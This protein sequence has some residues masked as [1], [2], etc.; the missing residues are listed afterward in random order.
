MLDK[1]K[2]INRYNIAA[3]SILF[4]YFFVFAHFGFSFDDGGYLYGAGWRLIIGEH[5]YSDYIYARPPMSPIISWFLQWILNDSH[6]Y[7]KIRYFFYAE[8]FIYS[9]LS[10]YLINKFFNLSKE[11]PIFLTGTLVFVINVHFNNYLWHTT[12]G[13]FFSVISFYFITKRKMFWGSVFLLFA[14]LS[15]QS[16]YPLLFMYPLFIYI[17]FKREDDDIGEKVENEDFIFFILNAFLVFTIF[18]MFILLFFNKEFFDYLSLHQEHTQLKPFL[19]AGF[20]VYLINSAFFW[21]LATI[22]FFFSEENRR[23][24]FN[25]KNKFSRAFLTKKTLDF[26]YVFNFS[27]LFFSLF[28]LFFLDS[29]SIKLYHMIISF[30]L[31][32]FLLEELYLFY[33][34]RE[35]RRFIFT[36]VFISIAWCS[37]LSWGYTTPAFYA[38]TILFLY[39]LHH[40]EI[41]D[42]KIILIIPI[43]FI[44]DSPI[45]LTERT[46]NQHDIGFFSKKLSGIYTTTNKYNDLKN[47]N[48][49]INECEKEHKTWSVFPDYTFVKYAKNSKPNIALDWI[50]NAEA[51]N[52]YDKIEKQIKDVKCLILHHKYRLKG[53]KELFNWKDNPQGY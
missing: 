43:L 5:L 7:L 40:R 20:I 14:V 52:K 2:V 45:L 38:G 46:I 35:Q 41:I 36:L 18:M 31:V 10:V 25:Y 12:D 11:F 24:L 17:F 28:L 49:K 47:I 34:K 6:E 13:I 42:K 9:F 23:L 1:L 44:L 4:L 39:F 26:L 48:K 27:I 22:L 21:I 51:M 37:S 8:V 16:F 3:I 53:K 29:P 15:K 50:S 33:R 32:V 30:I 19:K